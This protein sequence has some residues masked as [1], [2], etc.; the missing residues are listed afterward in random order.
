MGPK[1]DTITSTEKLS[2]CGT[3]TRYGASKVANILFA[4]ELARRHPHL[5]SVSVHPGLITTD[6]YASNK[7]SNPLGQIRYGRYWA[8]DNAECREG[9]VQPALGDC[10]S[11]KA[12]AYERRLLHSGWS[13]G[14]R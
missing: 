5:T 11:H 6:L 3:W 14:Q 1:L 8:L 10:W 13:T 2:A 12:G 4:A 7:K 9:S